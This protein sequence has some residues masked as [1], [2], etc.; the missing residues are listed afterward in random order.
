MNPVSQYGYEYDAWLISACMPSSIVRKLLEHYGTSEACHQAVFRNDNDLK[1]LMSHRF[2]QL[3]Y[4]T[5]TTENLEKYQKIMNTNGIRSLLF[6]DPLYPSSLHDIHDP[7]AV[8]FM[9]GNT[10]CLKDRSLAIVGSRA[11]SYT[12]Q[13][14]TLKLA[15]DLGRH[16]VT[17]ISG[18]ACGID[19][20]A[21]R[22]CLNGKGITIAVVGN[23][24]DRVYP[25]DNRALHDDILDSGGLIISEYAPGEKALGWHFPVRNR[26]IVGLSRAL[27]LMEARIRSGSMTSVNH[28]LDQGKDVFVYP[29]DPS[30]DS[31]EGNHQLL[32]EGG[33]YFTSA[34]D[35]LEDLHWLDNPPAVRQNSDCVQGYKPSTPEEETIIKAL[36]PGALSFEQ[37][38]SCT[39]LNPSALMSTLTILQI[40]GIIEALPGKQY[41][42]KH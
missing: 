33:L 23:G 17:V 31:F 26:I 29:G 3:L 39:G 30:S 28:A 40:R 42:L 18:L 35:I 5:G 13:K 22:G 41:H 9:Q 38:I 37:L 1:E 2:F 34:I 11:A 8:L 25:A 21:H 24:L 20:A 4:S 10:G 32:R 19:A 27:I 14:A 12:G 15:E 6:T 36:R 7:P 16:N